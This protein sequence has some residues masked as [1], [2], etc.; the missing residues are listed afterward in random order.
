MHVFASAIVTHQFSSTYETHYYCRWSTS[1]NNQLVMP[2]ENIVNGV[3]FPFK[4]L[5]EMNISARDL[6]E[7]YAPID[8]IEE[9]ESG[10]E[11]GLFVNCSNQDNV[12]FGSN[13]EYAY[14]SDREPIGFISGRLEDRYEVPDNIFSIT[15]GTC[16]EMNGSEC[17]SVLCLD[18]REI[19]DGE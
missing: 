8:V 12:W 3:P 14:D 13:C 11:T 5:R 15:N 1:K 2:N 17:Q 4:Y 9:Y 7:W 10:S 19:C 16:Y 6:F 18:W